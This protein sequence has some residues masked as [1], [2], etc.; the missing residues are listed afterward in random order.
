MSE[1]IRRDRKANARTKQPKY[2][3]KRSISQRSGS[4]TME[5]SQSNQTSVDG[6]MQTI[7]RFLHEL[8]ASPTSLD[9][10]STTHC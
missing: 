3:R 5:T 4:T 7:T 6:F 8:K 10:T 9:H 1:K 2:R